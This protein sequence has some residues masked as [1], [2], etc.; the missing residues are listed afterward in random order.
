MKT[1][2]WES[3]FCCGQVFAA[4]DKEAIDKAFK[5]MRW[6]EQENDKMLVIYKESVTK[7]GT[8]FVTVWA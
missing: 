7:D 8:P 1:Y 3:D 2:Y 6:F 4:T 5:K